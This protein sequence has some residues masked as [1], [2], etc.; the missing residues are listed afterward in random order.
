MPKG[1]FKGTEAQ[2]HILVLT[3]NG[4]RYQRT[5]IQK[6]YANGNLSNSIAFAGESGDRLDYDYNSMLHEKRHVGAVNCLAFMD[7]SIER[8]RL[9]SR[10]GRLAKF[11]VVHTSSFQRNESYLKLPRKSKFPEG[12]V[13]A[14]AGDILI[15]RV[16]RHLH[17]KVSL[18]VQGNAVMTDCVF[19]VQIPIEQREGVLRFLCSEQGRA[20]LQSVSRGAGARML[21]KSELLRMP[22]G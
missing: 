6:L 19:R 2:C 5:K 17:E 20:C 18:V 15:A 13:V 7:A 16:D 22:I 21:S 11:N 8:G 1:A 14:E 12:H 3:K 10:Q 4:G 9:T